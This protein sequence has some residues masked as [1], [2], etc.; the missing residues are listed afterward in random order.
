MHGPCVLQDIKMQVTIKS[1]L[2]LVRRRWRQRGLQ[3]GR[4][5]VPQQQQ[6]LWWWWLQQ[7]AR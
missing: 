7:R 6:R 1:Y 3:R 5:L 2:Q 4:Q